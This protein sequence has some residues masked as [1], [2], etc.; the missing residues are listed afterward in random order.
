MTATMLEVGAGQWTR[1]APRLVAEAGR[2]DNSLEWAHEAVDA[3]ALAGFWGFK[4]QMLDRETL[5]TRDA[6]GYGH[7]AQWD[8]FPPGL[9]RF[10]WAEIRDHCRE[11]GLVFFASCWDEDTVDMALDLGCPVL[12]V[13][14]AD[15]THEMLLRYVGNCGVPVWL[16]TGASLPEEIDRAVVWLDCETM[17]LACSLAYPCPVEDA[18]LQR[19]RLLG[20]LWP[21]I[22]VGYSDH[23][24]EPWIVGAAA[25]AGAQAVEAHWTVT[26]D[27]GGDHAFALHPGNVGRIWDPPA[28]VMFAPGLL[29]PMLSEMPA[30]RQARR[31]IAT[32]LPLDRGDRWRLTDLTFL[33]P[34]T[35]L[36]PRRWA[37]LVG[38]PVRRDYGAGELVDLW[39]IGG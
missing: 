23:C 15:I 38:C 18:A 2:C 14:S 29:G 26:P 24:A 39:E 25:D 5:V 6:E 33:R 35:G 21:G 20:E 11:R 16:S 36:E 4:V 12:K 1:P 3:A 31:S 34:G 19:I 28:P 13:G 8:D 37:D 7:G 9:G 17:L 30:R 27:L 32:R 10:D 22:P